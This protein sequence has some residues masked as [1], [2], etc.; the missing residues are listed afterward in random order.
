[1]KVISAADVSLHILCLCKVLLWAQK[2]I[3]L[4]S[5][6]LLSSWLP[7]LRQNEGRLKG[8]LVTTFLSGDKA[9]Q[10]REGSLLGDCW[11]FRRSSAVI[12]L[13]LLILVDCMIQNVR[14]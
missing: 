12:R 10:G 7:P 1:M 13:F 4:I 14:E 11:R 6:A 8:T 2:Q 9:V 3:P 5:L